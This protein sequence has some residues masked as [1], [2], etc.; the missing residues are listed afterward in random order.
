MH[1]LASRARQG[2]ATTGKSSLRA[3]IIAFKKQH[4]YI[5]LLPKRRKNKKT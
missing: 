1:V 5:F 4:Y 3:G 2:Q